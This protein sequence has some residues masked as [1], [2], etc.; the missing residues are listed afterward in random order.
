MGY[1]LRFLFR[2]SLRS[3]R[4]ALQ[5]VPLDGSMATV[6]DFY[7]DLWLPSVG[8]VRLPKQ[9]PGLASLPEPQSRQRIQAGCHERF[10]PQRMNHRFQTLGICPGCVLH[11]SIQ[12]C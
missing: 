5:N 6:A 2:L 3:G 7:A 9:F 4:A 1:E 11:H 12:G 8:M 10:I